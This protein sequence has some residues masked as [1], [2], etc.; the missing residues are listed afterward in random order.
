MGTMLATGSDVVSFLKSQHDEI[1][2]LFA[3]VR[4]VRGEERADAFYSLRRLLA[5]HETAE[6]EIV[7]PVARRV[8][9]DGAEIIEKRLQEE[10]EAKT[11]LA[12]LESVD[13]ESAE[14]DEK[15]EALQRDVIAHAESE[16]REEFSRLADALDQTKLERMRKAAEIAEKVAPTRPHPGVESAVANIFAGP[17][18]SMV[19]RVRDALE[20]KD[21][22]KE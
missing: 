14:F 4:E 20:N 6:E 11:A 22:K 12:A 16:E 17:F 21:E 1:K 10:H 9:P 5:V 15:I 7:H 2:E 13:V 18:A 19:D 8:L 3:R